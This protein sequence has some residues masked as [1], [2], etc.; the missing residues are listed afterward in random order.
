MSGRL[1][2]VVRGSVVVP[3]DA[4]ELLTANGVVISTRSVNLVRY[5]ALHDEV[6]SIIGVGSL[7]VVDSGVFIRFL[8]VL[9]YCRLLPHYFLPVA[10]LLWSYIMVIHGQMV[11]WPVPS[12]LGPLCLLFD[13]LLIVC[14]L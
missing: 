4:I 12:G 3:A 6:F 2:C 9:A 8:R 5:D 1:P 10:G 11:A 14:A 7:F 13:V